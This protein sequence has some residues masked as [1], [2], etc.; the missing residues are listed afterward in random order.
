VSD[1]T[2]QLY[3]FELTTNPNLVWTD[4]KKLDFEPGAPVQTLNPDSI[5]LVGDVTADYHLAPVPY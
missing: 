2:S 4:L 1:P 5:D 3:F